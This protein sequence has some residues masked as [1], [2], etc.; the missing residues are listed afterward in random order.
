MTLLG[1]QP[2]PD[3]N[4]LRT[5][6]FCR[7]PDR[8]P[9]AELWIDAPVKEAILGRHI[10]NSFVDPDYDV[11][12]D[13]DFMYGAG[14]DYVHVEPRYSFPMKPGLEVPEN[15]G[16][17]LNWADFADYPWPTIADVD[18]HWLDRAV[19]YLPSGMGIITGTSGIF[20]AAWR[21]TGF[22]TFCLLMHDQPDLV[23]AIM[24]RVG[25]LLLQIFERGAAFPRVGAMWISDDIAYASGP[26]LPP[27][28][29][30]QH[31]FPWYRQ[32]AD[33]CRQRDLPF[34]YHSDGLL[35]KVLPDLIAAGFNA[36]QP[37]EP[38]VMDI[39]ELKRQVGDRLCLIG[40]IDLGYTLTRGT[41][42][43]VEAEVRERIR[44]V[45]PGGGYCVGSSNTV[46][47]YVPP[48]NYIAMIEATRRYGKY[49]LE[50]V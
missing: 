29:Y 19:Q 39:V 25:A 21:I 9:L 6:L 49:P 16:T 24:Q 22:T 38:K 13:I 50:G 4:R 17:V 8:V 44:T 47:Y 30:R 10:G 7:Q 40:N 15:A 12:A 11:E 35:W 18:F 5:A 31:L 28:F 32:M 26:M 48:Q 14:Y 2:D 41:P 37:I 23:A 46:T 27:A 43:E 36:I 42:A 33:I 3:F 45:G 20:E 1:F 34:L